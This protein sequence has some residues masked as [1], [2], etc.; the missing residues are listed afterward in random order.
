[1]LVPLFRELSG[2]L[3][4]TTK[5]IASALKRYVHLNGQFLNELRPEI[6]SFVQAVELVQR[7]ESLGLPL[8]Q[9]EIASSSERICEISDSYKIQLALRLSNQKPGMNLAGPVIPNEVILGS[10]G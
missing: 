2:V 5:P 3:E 7:L 4:K 1:M 10:R 9:P 8:C 6:I